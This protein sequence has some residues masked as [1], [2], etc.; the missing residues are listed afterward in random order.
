MTPSKD[1]VL[2]A[3]VMLRPAGGRAIDGRVPITAEN[4]AEFTPSPGTA[5]SAIAALRAGG[6]DVGPLVGAS[7]SVTGT[8][9]TFE[10]FFGLRLRLGRDQAYEFIAGRQSL[11]HE[12]SGGHLPEVLRDSVQAVAFPLPPDFGPTGF[13]E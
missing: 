2:S 9:R 1:V 6:L 5:S 4:V 8:I 13:H 12:L 7:F 10:E 11:G 3:Q